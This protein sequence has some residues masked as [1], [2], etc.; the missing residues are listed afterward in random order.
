MTSE[1]MLLIVGNFTV[2][3]VGAGM[4]VCRMAHMSARFTKGAIRIQYAVLF[5]MF[6]ASAISWTYDE[7]A[8]VTQL[9]M[10]CGMLAHLL[11]GFEAWRGGA[12]W[13]T[14]RDVRT[15]YEVAGD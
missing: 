1:T 6:A 13:Y 9:L 8:T 5:A 10:S 2:C 4:C 11:L 14:I 3:G 7:P 15:S 12:P